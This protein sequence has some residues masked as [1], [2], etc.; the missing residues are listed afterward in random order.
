MITLS[1]QGFRNT[2]I[3]YYSIT[4]FDFI[5]SFS[6]PKLLDIVF[7]KEIVY[8]FYFRIVTASNCYNDQLAHYT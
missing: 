6:I 2:E 3:V 8:R 4:N 7:R 5:H 1:V